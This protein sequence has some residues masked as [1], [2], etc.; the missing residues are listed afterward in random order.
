MKDAKKEAKNGATKKRERSY[1]AIVMGA[2]AG[3]VEAYCKVLSMLPSDFRL[4]VVLCL[5]MAEKSKAVL[6]EVISGVTKI[7]CKEGEDK[8]DVLPGH[9]YTAP[10]GYHLLIEQ[11]HSLSL[12][13][14]DPVN[15]SRPSI[16]VLFESAAYAYKDKL[17]GILLTGAN[18]DGAEGL[19]IIRQLGGLTIVQEPTSAL[20]PQ[21]PTAAI[22][23][24]RPDHVM[25]LSEIGAFAAGLRNQALE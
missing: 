14:E 23:A 21:M 9:I 19:D 22:R 5:H 18:D 25:T 8:E 2:S 3:G 15:F 13:T 17:V 16:N 11:N 4:A 6:P 7:P 20:A 24:G 10:P 1:C 12:S